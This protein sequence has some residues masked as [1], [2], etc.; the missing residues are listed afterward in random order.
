M[1]VFSSKLWLTPQ[2]FFLLQTKNWL[3]QRPVDWHLNAFF[4]SHHG[5]GLLQ[6]A[7]S[8]SENKFPRIVVRVIRASQTSF[9]GLHSA[10]DRARTKNNEI[11]KLDIRSQD[12]STTGCILLYSYLH[13]GIA[14]TLFPGQ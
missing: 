6:I 5:I 9:I 4:E 3:T 1:A 7:P 2:S 10:Y 13:T 11:N 14:R 12:S 8:S